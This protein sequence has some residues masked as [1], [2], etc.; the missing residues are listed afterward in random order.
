MT[1]SRKIWHLSYSLRWHKIALKF[2]PFGKLS[3]WFRRQKFHPKNFTSPARFPDANMYAVCGA[4]LKDAS[5][6]SIGGDNWKSRE[7]SD[8]EDAD[9]ARGGKQRRGTRAQASP[10]HHACVFRDAWERYRYPCMLRNARAPHS[11]SVGFCR[12][13]CRVFS[14]RLVAATRERRLSNSHFENF[15]P[16]L[17][18]VLKLSRSMQNFKTIIMI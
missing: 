11:C 2:V 3:I 9:G 7:L 13:T 15:S 10:G 4:L 6:Q 8:N 14:D 18:T 16:L 17:Q 12:R 5:C 1:I